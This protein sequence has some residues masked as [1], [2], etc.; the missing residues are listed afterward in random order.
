MNLLPP[1]DIELEAYKNGAIL[2]DL[3]HLGVIKVNGED[4]SEFLQNQLSNDIQ[5]VVPTQSQLSAYCTP[6]GRVFSLLRLIKYGECFFLQLPKERLEP[7]LERLKMYVLM[8]K[9]TLTD[10]ADEFISIGCTGK[11]A[12]TKLKTLLGTLPKS[13]DE[14]Y[15]SDGLIITR[16][17]GND[18]FMISGPFNAVSKVWQQLQTTVQP[19]CQGVWELTNIHSGIP[20]I[21]DVNAGAFVPQMLNLDLIGAVSFTK[22]CYPGQEIVARTRY[23]GKLK[24]RLY[25]TYID[26]TMPPRPGDSLVTNEGGSLQSVGVVVSAAVSPSGG[27]DCLAVIQIASAESSLLYSK[28][29]AV[30]KV[31]LKDLPYSVEVQEEND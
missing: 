3:S 15:Q 29:D 5:K 14:C 9:A 4:A 13:L 23:L 26:G 25:M 1:P 17:T 27:F 12:E 11:D 22:G 6:N 28:N 7:T 2:C 24:R 31:F 10:A 30:S 8:S 16:L 20:D 21:Y 18:R 19:V